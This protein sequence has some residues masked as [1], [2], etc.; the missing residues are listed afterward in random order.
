MEKSRSVRA[1]ARLKRL[2]ICLIEL[3]GNR[4]GFHLVGGVIRHRTKGGVNFCLFAGSG[5]QF[6][7]ATVHHP[8]TSRCLELARF[9]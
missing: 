6:I 7:A 4:K 5:N 3:G 9:G 8:Y 2:P 1:F